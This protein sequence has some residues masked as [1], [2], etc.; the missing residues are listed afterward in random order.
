M[1]RMRVRLSAPM[2]LIRGTLALTP[3]LSPH[4]PSPIGLAALSR[5]RSGWER[6]Q[7]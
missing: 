7:G 5:R 4:F 2:T 1:Y 6:G 3:A